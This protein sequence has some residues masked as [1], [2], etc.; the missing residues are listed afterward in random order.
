VSDPRP[1]PGRNEKRIRRACWLAL[2]ALGLIVWS[3]VHPRPMPVIVAMSVGQVIG[4][5]SLLMFL[6]AVFAD[7]RA[8][9]G[10]VLRRRSAAADPP[11]R[12]AEPPST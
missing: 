11:P 3:Q 9:L 12:D 4:T 2:V 1:A 7:V 5:L 8:V 10:G 6:H